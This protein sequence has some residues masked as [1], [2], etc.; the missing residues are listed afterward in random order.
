MQTF[1]RNA[2]PLVSALALSSALLVA[3]AACDKHSDSAPAPN[4]VQQDTTATGAVE[5]AAP[6]AKAPTYDPGQLAVFSPLPEKIERPDN[7]L[8]DDKVALGKML[9]FDARLSLSQDVSCNSCHD[10]TK[11]G[12]DTEAIP[13][14]TKKQKGRRN[15]PTIFNDAGEFAQGW[16]AHYQLVEEM[17]VPHATDPTVMGADEKRLVDTISSVPAYAAAFKK[18]FPEAKGAINADTVSKAIGAYTRKLLTPGRWDKFLAGDATALTDEEKGG[19]GTFL[20]VNCNSCHA[21]KYMGGAQSQKLGLAKP[22]PTSTDLGRYDVTKQDVDKQMFKVPT[23]R[24]VTKTA[25]YLHDG[26]LATLDETVKMMGRHQ[27]GKELTE[28]Q[29]KYLVAFLG[30]LAGDAPKDLVSKPELPPS[31]PKTPKP[32]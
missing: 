28:A 26:S 22:W 10:V 24:N 11:S 29:V 7:L 20:E 9:W 14:G 23:L 32:G 19:L 21:G 3:A 16:D 31:G 27:L 17:V 8:S 4:P 1:A 25:P 2:L 6:A 15:A 5:P 12:A 18:A 13:S 30:A